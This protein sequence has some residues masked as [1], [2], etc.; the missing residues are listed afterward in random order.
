M[1]IVLA[2]KDG[3]LEWVD[4]ALKAGVAV[5]TTDRVSECMACWNN[6]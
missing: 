3:L 5:D 4:N 6:V 1:D 2:A